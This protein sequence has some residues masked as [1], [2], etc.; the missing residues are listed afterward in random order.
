MTGLSS[1]MRILVCFNPSGIFICYAILFVVG[2]EVNV[3]DSTQGSAFLIPAQEVPGKQQIKGNNETSGSAVWLCG[4]ACE[5][6]NLYNH[7][8]DKF[9]HKRNHRYVKITLPT[10]IK[11]EW[12]YPKRSKLVFSIFCHC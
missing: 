1:V 6:V 10:V 2:A 11:G 9:S 7:T 5:G 8:D 3:N 4:A 12:Y